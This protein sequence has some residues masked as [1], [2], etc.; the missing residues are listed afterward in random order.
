MLLPRSARGLTV[1]TLPVAAAP[2]APAETDGAP[3]KQGEGAEVVRLDRF[4]KKYEQKPGA[5][6]KP[7]AAA[8]EKKPA[9]KKKAD[10]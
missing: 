3:A 9:T 5:A 1:E 6:A 2:E 7:A 10:A 4:R 8:A